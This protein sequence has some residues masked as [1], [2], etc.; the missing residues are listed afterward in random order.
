MLQRPLVPLDASPAAEQVL[1]LAAEVARALQ[2]PLALLSVV[3]DVREDEALNPVDSAQDA[4]LLALTER[5]LA[6]AQDYLDTVRARLEEQGVYASVETATG[7]P[8]DRILEAAHA[9]GSGLIVMA[10]HA[11]SAPERWFLGS[12]ADRVVRTAPVPVLLIRPQGDGPHAPALSHLVVPLDGSAV[13]EEVLPLVTYLATTLHLPVTVVR[14]TS[15]ARLSAYGV[16]TTV[17]DALEIAANEY[18]LGVVARLRESGITARASFAFAHPADAI[19]AV[20]R[21]IPGALIVMGT[22]GRS[23]LARALLGSVTDRVVRSSSA[24]VMV[25]PRGAAQS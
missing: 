1:P 2:Q 4:A 10:T 23:G 19:E 9:R 15:L 5:R 25:V 17:M 7:R 18:L 13:A 8:A 21:G 3:T 14:A 16:D 22:H 24:P 12:V 20:A 6:F 11:R